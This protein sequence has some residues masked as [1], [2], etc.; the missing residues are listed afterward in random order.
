MIDDNYNP[1]IIDFGSSNNHLNYTISYVAPEI[2]LCQNNLIKASVFTDIYSYSI[3]CSE[4]ILMKYNP[5]IKLSM[6]EIKQKL[7]THINM[8]ENSPLL[9]KTWPITRYLFPQLRDVIIQ[10]LSLK[11]I[12][13]PNLSEFQECFQEI[14]KHENEKQ[15]VITNEQEELEYGP[16]YELMDEQTIEQAPEI[17]NNHDNE[18]INTDNYQQEHFK[19]ESNDGVKYESIS[20]NYELELK[21]KSKNIEPKSNEVKVSAQFIDFDN[22]NISQQKHSQMKLQLPTISELIPL[23]QQLYCKNIS[24]TEVVY[25][26]RYGCHNAKT[27]VDMTISNDNRKICSRCQISDEKNNERQ[28]S[29]DIYADIEVNADCVLAEATFIDVNTIDSYQTATATATKMSNS[30]Y[31]DNNVI[32]DSSMKV[33]DAVKVDYK[34][35]NNTI[36]NTIK[37]IQKSVPNVSIDSTNYH[38]Y[39]TIRGS[40]YHLKYNCS[41]ATLPINLNQY[42]HNESNRKLYSETTTL[43]PCSKCASNEFNDYY[44]KLINESFPTTKLYKTKYGSSYHRLGCYHIKS[45]CIEIKSNEYGKLSLKSCLKCCEDIHIDMD[46]KIVKKI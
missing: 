14:I 15:I 18:Q 25:H 29:N 31:D 23:N 39:K 27:S 46:G 6:N 7:S 21:E 2:L 26:T 33:L 42:Q 1:I 17:E 16:V 5:F 12:E 34:I 4:V 22:S 20:F 45:S 38:C 40:C 10:G 24:N 30:Y 3:V 41:G 36:D 43:L 11:A 35:V 13:R 8:N 37:P 28:K 19:Q 32:E 44:N 9:L